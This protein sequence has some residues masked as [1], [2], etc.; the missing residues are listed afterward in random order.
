MAIVSH[1]PKNIYGN[2]Q[3]LLWFCNTEFR[4]SKPSK[5]AISLGLWEILKERWQLSCTRDLKNGTTVDITF[6]DQAL[7]Y[8]SVFE[9][10]STTTLRLDL[11]ELVELIQTKCVIWL[12]V[13]FHR[14]KE[15]CARHTTRIYGNGEKRYQH[16]P[17]PSFGMQ[18]CVR[19]ILQRL[20]SP[21]TYEKAT[22]CVRDMAGVTGLNKYGNG[23]NY[24]PYSKT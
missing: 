20:P 10:S 2:G 1:T 5:P 3:E 7:V 14:L 21:L 17:I 19:G 24:K 9:Q 13:V 6:Q 12:A 15:S 4:S 22:Q 11:W 16:I 18:L 23:E 8:F